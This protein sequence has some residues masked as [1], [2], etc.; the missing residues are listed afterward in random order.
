MHPSADLS[1]NLTCD[2][3]TADLTAFPGVGLVHESK[4]VQY[5]AI[6]Y[7][8]GYPA[9]TKLTKC[10][11]V[12]LPTSEVA[13][14]ALCHIRKPSAACYIWIDGCCIN[15]CD[16]VEKSRQVG[17]M[18]TIFKKASRVIAWLGM[19]SSADEFLFK[20][21]KDT[22]H[23]V[24]IEGAIKNLSSS[25]EIDCDEISNRLHVVASSFFVSKP[26]FRRMWIRQEFLAAR[27][28]HFL[29]GTDSCDID[30]LS[31]LIDNLKVESDRDCH[32]QASGQVQAALCYKYIR[33]DHNVNNAE[34]GEIADLTWFQTIMRSTIYR[35]TLPH[36]KIYA[37]LGIAK[38]LTYKNKISNTETGMNGTL[39]KA[40]QKSTIPKTLVKY[41]RI[42]SNIQSTQVTACDV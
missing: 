20:V 30:R 41:I 22:A 36:D 27:D 24:P 38:A 7:S 1:A 21:V 40:F 3:L 6:S 14:E 25:Y 11:G 5:E 39:H 32:P 4:I 34:K 18:F 19:P 15:Q 26:L 23:G 2:L 42:L 16:P 12:A 10:N 28:L 31:D 35:A 9:L 29:C 8:W 33:S 17:M 13:H 37:V